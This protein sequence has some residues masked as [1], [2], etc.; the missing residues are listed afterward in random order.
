MIVRIKNIEALDNYIL[1]VT[2]DDD[3]IVEYDMK[4]DINKLSG[5][6]DLKNIDGLWKKVSI[7]KSRTCIYWNDYIDLASDIIYEYGKEK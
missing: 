5:Y 7:D 3:K 4:E 6:S 1:R 2:F